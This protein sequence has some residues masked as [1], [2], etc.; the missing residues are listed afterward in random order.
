MVFEFVL[1]VESFGTTE[2]AID[3]QAIKALGSV[4]EHMPFVLVA[5]FESFLIVA[6][7][8]FTFELLLDS[9]DL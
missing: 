2:L 1:T 9:R 5:A 6:A 4:L 7:S 8:P 3:S